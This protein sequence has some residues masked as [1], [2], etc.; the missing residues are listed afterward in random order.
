M[1]PKVLRVRDGPRDRVAAHF[2]ERLMISV[3]YYRPV[4]G[5]NHG[6]LRSLS[7]NVATGRPTFLLETKLRHK[8]RG[9]EW[10]LLSSHL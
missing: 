3:Q 4:Q 8:K 1:N 5:M 7:P 6:K 10:T 9:K 2:S